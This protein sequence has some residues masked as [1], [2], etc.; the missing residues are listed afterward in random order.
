MGRVA[1][2]AGQLRA[3]ARVTRPRSAWM[4]GCARRGPSVGRWPSSSVVM[5]CTSAAA[6]RP[7]QLPTRSIYK[8]LYT[9]CC[10]NPGA[11]VQHKGLHC[12]PAPPPP[13]PPRAA[14]LTPPETTPKLAPN[15]LKQGYSHWQDG[16]A[17]YYGRTLFGLG[18]V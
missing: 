6:P 9:S 11:E 1:G 16:R 17:T 7:I 15:P 5:D 10:A 14:H 3:L 13:P 4:G 18:W 8:I 12:V 2:L